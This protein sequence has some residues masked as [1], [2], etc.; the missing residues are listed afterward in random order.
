MVFDE[1]IMK[2]ISEGKDIH[3]VVI[4]VVDLINDEF[5]IF[6]MVFLLYREECLMELV[7]LLNVVVDAR[8]AFNENEGAKFSDGILK[9]FDPYEWAYMIVNK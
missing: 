5:G 7:K 3:R 1:T 9:H 2:R 6:E 8:M 4:Q